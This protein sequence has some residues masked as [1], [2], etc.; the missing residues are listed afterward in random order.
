[1]AEGRGEGGAGDGA[2]GS[3]GE[4]RAGAER[5]ASRTVFSG[6]RIQMRV[7]RIRLPNGAEHELELIHHP[8]AAAIVPLLD[9]GEV[10][11]VRQYRY[12]TGGWLLEV[13]A[14]TLNAGESP[15]QCA[16][17]ELREETG[18]RAGALQ[19]LGWIWTTPGF[20]DERIWLYLATALEGGDQALEGDEQLTVERLPLAQAAAMAAGGEIVDGKSVAGLL[21]AAARRGIPLIG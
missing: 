20:T 18:F 10:V 15:E 19:P 7:D 17:R 8:G 2:A 13:P 14:G 21:R 6:R 5:L 4:Q 16:G 11:L 3:A 9:S 12:A 1:M